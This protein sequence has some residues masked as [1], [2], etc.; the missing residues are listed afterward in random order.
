VAVNGEERITW[1]AEQLELSR[2]QLAAMLRGHDQV[3]A[4]NA[5][6]AGFRTRAVATL[7]AEIARDEEALRVARDTTRYGFVTP[8]PKVTCGVQPGE[9]LT[10]P[11][12]LRQLERRYPSP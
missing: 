11:A 1:L 3:P 9:P 6:Q 12:A 7:R 8:N 10:G 2:L 4:E 5:I